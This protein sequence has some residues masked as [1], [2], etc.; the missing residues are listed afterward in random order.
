LKL[1][2]NHALAHVPHTAYVGRMKPARFVGPSKGGQRFGGHM[3]G[4]S[5]ERLV[6]VLSSRQNGEFTVLRRHRPDD[7]GRSRKAPRSSMFLNLFSDADPYPH[8]KFAK[9]V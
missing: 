8:F 3:A 4:F 6:H 5:V 9:C 7:I 2:L 1:S